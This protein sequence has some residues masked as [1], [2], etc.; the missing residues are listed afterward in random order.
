MT[1]LSESPL[2]IYYYL[3]ESSHLELRIDRYHP[4]KKLTS[5]QTQHG[6]R[7]TTRADGWQ[8]KPQPGRT[9]APPYSPGALLARQRESVSVEEVPVPTTMDPKDVIIKVTGTTICE[10]DLP[11]KVCF[12]GRQA[13][14]NAARTDGDR[15]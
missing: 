9:R 6:N 1:A 2:G 12:C 7:S 15:R 3:M 8:P 10:S 13:E 5:C 11:Q 14:I 4:T